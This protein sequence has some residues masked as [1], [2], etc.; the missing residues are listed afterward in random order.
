LLFKNLN[1]KTK[2]FL[3]E[4]KED[5]MRKFRAIDYITLTFMIILLIAGLGSLQEVLLA[6]HIAYWERLKDYIEKK[7]HRRDEGNPFKERAG[8]L[9]L[10]AWLFFAAVAL[11]LNQTFPCDYHLPLEHILIPLSIVLNKY[12]DSKEKEVKEFLS[13]N[14]TSIKGKII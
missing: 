13:K 8:E 4:F 7:K 10:L 6:F 1:T 11:T 9:W 5:K 14:F 3:K 2:E 12:Y